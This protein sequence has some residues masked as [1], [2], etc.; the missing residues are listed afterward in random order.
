M[1][2]VV[3]QGWRNARYAFEPGYVLPINPA[4]ALLILC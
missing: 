2:H 1:H 3:S 4:Y